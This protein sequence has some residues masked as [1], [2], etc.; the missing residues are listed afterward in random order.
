MLGGDQRWLRMAY[1]LLFALPG[2]PTLFYGEEI[3]MGEN[4][5]VEDRLAVRT[6]MQWTD[7]PTAGFSTAPADG[8]V[9]PA[10]ADGRS[11][12]PAVVNVADQRTD[13]DSLLN[14]FERRIRLHRRRSPSAD[15]PWS[16]SRSSRQEA[17]YTHPTL[18]TE[19]VTGPATN[20]TIPFRSAMGW[21]VPP[22]RLRPPLVPPRRQSAGR[23][24]WSAWRERSFTGLSAIIATG[25]SGRGALHTPAVFVRRP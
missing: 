22:R 8:L 13:P 23:G 18:P 9:P 3:G 4:L 24:C 12:A 15:T 10:A 19:P 20:R 17:R 21:L 11:S 6:P 25:R 2:T 1:S 5:E 14:W 16:P 7:G